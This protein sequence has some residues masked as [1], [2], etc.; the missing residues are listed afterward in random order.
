VAEVAYRFTD[1]VEREIAAERKRLL[2]F[3]KMHLITSAQV[4]EM[5][6]SFVARRI[7]AARVEDSPDRP[8]GVNCPNCSK[9]HIVPASISHIQCGCAPGMDIVTALNRIPLS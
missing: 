5:M 3:R 9:L 2:R 8:I 4:T 1:S 6:E 7:Y